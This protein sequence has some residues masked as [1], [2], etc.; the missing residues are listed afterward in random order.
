M[1]E[2]KNNPENK[3]QKGFTSGAL[4]LVFLILGYQIAVFVHKAASMKLAADRDKPDTVYVYLQPDPASPAPSIPPQV[5]RTERKPYSGRPAAVAAA[6][7]KA[8]PRKVESFAFNPNTVTLEE[9]VRLGFSEKQAAA[10][11]NYRQKG[12]RFARPADFSKS[13]VVSDSIYTR[14]EP[15]IQIP[16]L[17]INTADSTALL[18]LPG[19]GPWFASKI[20]SYRERLGGYH[21]VEQLLEIRNFTPEKLDGMRDLITLSPVSPFELWTLPEE[22]LSAHPYISPQEAHGIVL[23][24]LHHSPSECTVEALQKN[25]VLREEHAALIS[26]LRISHP[27]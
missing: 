23:F 27:Q 13:F 8:V 26:R 16:R 11:D 15:Y 19:I 25:G 17:D 9:L 5:K 4:A 22:K 14:L 2:G 10:I 1:E 21:T 6:R 7:D 24:R 18:D 12:G 20:I 3:L